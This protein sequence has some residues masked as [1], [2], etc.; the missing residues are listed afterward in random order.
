M[1]QKLRPFSGR[2]KLVGKR[3]GRVN[4]FPLQISEARSVGA[5]KKATPWGDWA[6]EAY[7]YDT[8]KER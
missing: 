1:V 6:K 5:S 8:S 7:E 3:K 4:D 2:G